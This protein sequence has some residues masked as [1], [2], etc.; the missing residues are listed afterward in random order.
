MYK[1]RIRK[2]VAKFID[3]RSP[4]QRKKIAEALLELEKDPYR[5]NLDIAALKGSSGKYRL[6]IG[7][8]RFLYMIIQDQLLIYLYKAGARGDVYK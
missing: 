6:R 8:C 4:K 7:T 5:N 1:L 2:Q 3:S